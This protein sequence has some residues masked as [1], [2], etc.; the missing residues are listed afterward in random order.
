MRNRPAKANMLYG[1]RAVIEAIEAGRDLERIFIQ[2]GLKGDL[3]K[4]LYNLL[5][6]LT[7]PLSTVPIERINKFTGKN[8]QGVVA[9]LSPIKYQP[10]EELVTST[11]ESGESPFFL[12][13]D[14]IT[15][16]RNFGALARTAEACGVHG[17]I[18][19]TKNAAQV[20]A[21][22]VKT[23]AGALNSI[24]VCR[25]ERLSQAIN[26]LKSS[27]LSTIACSEKG[28]QTLP[29]AKIELPVA[30]ILGSEEDGISPEVLKLSD[31][32]C[33]IPMKGKIASLNVSA[34]GAIF[35]Y[36]VARQSG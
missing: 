19:P 10:F 29:D 22:A 20:N 6:G 14:R 3:I 33:S 15:D 17:I 27:G 35:M 13:L 28:N 5:P 31:Q 24:P 7:V 18:I 34:A 16:V 36:E 8:H 32:I 30:L 12:V 11:F 1:I 23:S 9:F 25:V 21:D 2:K 4:E 26:F